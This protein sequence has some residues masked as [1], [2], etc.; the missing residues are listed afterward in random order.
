MYGDLRSKLEMY[1]KNREDNTKKRKSTGRDVQ[2]LINGTVCSNDMGTYFLIEKEYP[3]SYIYGGYRFED[4]KGVNLMSLG[5][6][7]SGLNESSRIQDFLFMDTETTGLSGGAGTVA[8]LVG[9][10]FFMDDRFILRQYFMRDYDEES[11]LLSD[12]NGFMAGYKGLVTFNGKAFDW[13]LLQSRFVFNRLRS[14]LR[15]PIHIDLLFPSRRIWKLKL[16]NCRL[17]TLE[18]NILGESRTDDIPGAMIP[19]I[20]FKYLE[21]RDASEIKRVIKHNELDILSLTAL[22]IKISFMLE[23]PLFE[24]DGERELFG[25]G[26]IFENAGE[27][28]K[29]I[30]CYET[31]TSSGNKYIRESALR[32]LGDIHKRNKDYD[33]AAE[34]WK[35][36]ISDSDAFS[37]YPVIEL[38][39]YYEH[40]CKDLDKALEMTE[41]AMQQICR[42]G[43]K[44]SCIYEEVEKRYER[45]KRKVGKMKNA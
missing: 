8:F 24:T 3:L 42:M 32:K 38:A 11:A 14:S 12:L 23:K 19:S 10:G 41:R 7:C 36:M 4:A 29:V 6:I 31:C 40:R 35:R 18:Q 9:I 13:S 20:Y 26:T 21:D 16:E 33:K 5:G 45:L 39:K 27:Y 43:M 34:H 37:L 1:K 30:G 25:V 2:N 15:N 17:G 22:F 28:D 44:K